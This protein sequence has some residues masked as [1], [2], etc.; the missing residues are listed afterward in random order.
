MSY[1]RISHTWWLIILSIQIFDWWVYYFIYSSLVVATVSWLRLNNI[2]RVYQII[3]YI[4]WNFLIYRIR[5]FLS[6]AGIPPTIGFYLKLI[7]LSISRLI[8]IGLIL[9]LRLSLTVRVY[10]YSMFFLNAML[11][12]NKS[13]HKVN[14]SVRK[15][16][17]IR[18]VILVGPFIF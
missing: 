4:N 2:K 1:S 14:F 13:V 12:R 5:L 17:F 7:V 9:L 6:L 10:Y 8:N 16:L 18:L 15:F 3:I 11:I